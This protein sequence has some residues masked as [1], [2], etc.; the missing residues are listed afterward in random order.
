MHGGHYGT[1]TKPSR[2]DFITGRLPRRFRNGSVKEGE[3]RR[4]GS[5][6]IQIE[7]LIQSLFFSPWREGLS[8]G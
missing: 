2:K 1:V 7:F 3:E 5:A 8:V 4:C 6:D